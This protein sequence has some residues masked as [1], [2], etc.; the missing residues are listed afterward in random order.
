MLSA[1]LDFLMATTMQLAQ[2]FIQ[3]W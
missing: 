1:I 2:V 3:T